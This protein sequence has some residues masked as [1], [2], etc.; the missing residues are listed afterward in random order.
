MELKVKVCDICMRELREVDSEKLSGFGSI[1]FY[2]D[3]GG[4]LRISGHIKFDDLCCECANEIKTVLD[5][6]VKISKNSKKLYK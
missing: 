4:S 1:H 2:S 5:K 3:L 6:Y